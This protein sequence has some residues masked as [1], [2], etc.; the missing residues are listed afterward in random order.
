MYQTDTLPQMRVFVLFKRNAY[1]CNS[2]HF[3]FNTRTYHS[4]KSDQRH[5]K[6]CFLMSTLA[7][8]AVIA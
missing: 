1:Y 3:M 5:S 2:N 4:S 7:M 6:Y 8:D